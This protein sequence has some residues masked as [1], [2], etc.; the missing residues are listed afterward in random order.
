[1]PV[2]DR[3]VTIPEIGTRR[4]TAQAILAGCIHEFERL[5]KTKASSA[6]ARVKL[7]QIQVAAAILGKKLQTAKASEVDRGTRE[8]GH[9][10]AELIKHLESLLENI[11]GL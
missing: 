3:F 10:N 4:Q 9:H 8:A 11:Q 5:P 2:T 1:M 6:D 7:L